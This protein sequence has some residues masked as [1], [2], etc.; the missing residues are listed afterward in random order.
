M[1]DYLYW[2]KRSDH[3]ERLPMEYWRKEQEREITDTTEAPEVKLQNQAE[4]RGRVQD[5]HISIE[6]RRL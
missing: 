2:E 6:T 5:L 3:L 4:P 1:C